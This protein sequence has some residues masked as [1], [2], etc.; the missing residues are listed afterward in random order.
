MKS[1]T[2]PFLLGVLLAPA[3]AAAA[4]G[5]GEGAARRLLDLSLPREALAEVWPPPSAGNAMP[6][7]D[8][9]GSRMD[10]A[11][12]ARQGGGL[13]YGAGYEARQ[14]T[15]GGGYGRGRGRGR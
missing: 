7:P 14:S 13:P 10:H 15:G 3:L 11:G 4:D 9:G 1:A 2:L 6:L 8:L 12:A 5:A